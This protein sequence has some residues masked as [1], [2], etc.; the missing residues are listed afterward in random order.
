MDLDEYFVINNRLDSEETET[1]F[2]LDWYN[3]AD[4]TYSSDLENYLIPASHENDDNGEFNYGLIRIVNSY[5]ACTP[6]A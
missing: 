5:I 6:T 1:Y 3:Q 2:N 4:G